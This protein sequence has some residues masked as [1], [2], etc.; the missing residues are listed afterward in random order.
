VIF[1][2]K[3]TT[4][5]AKQHLTVVF[6]QYYS[7]VHYIHVWVAR[8]VD[9]NRDALQSTRKGLV[10]THRQYRIRTNTLVST[11][12]QYRIRTNTLVSTH[13]QYRVRSNTLVSTHRQYRIRTNTLVSTHRQ[14][15][16]RTNTETT[17]QQLLQLQLLHQQ[18]L[19]LLTVVQ[20]R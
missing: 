20:E 4:V 7:Y 17:H 12:R 3:L 18:L 1:S 2:L 15:R 10:S 13:R 8:I 5:N 19:Q 6:L 11:H 14:Y 9:R 16:L